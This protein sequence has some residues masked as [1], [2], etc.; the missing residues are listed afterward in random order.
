[1]K[2]K[3]RISSPNS[4][5]TRLNKRINYSATGGVGTGCCACCP[6]P[7]N[8]CDEPVTGCCDNDL[9][10]DIVYAHLSDAGGC[11][12]ING[13]TIPLDIIEP[14]RNAWN[15]SPGSSSG[16]TC[17]PG[18]LPSS[19]RDAFLACIDGTYN[20]T[21]VCG[22]DNSGAGDAISVTCDPF[23]LT[24]LLDMTFLEQNTCCDGL[25]SVVINTTP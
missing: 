11:S 17:S 13:T 16:G 18:Q 24:F 21:F 23:R 25:V 3:V 7:C 1:M 15:Y 5:L 14:E 22:A 20:F 4:G 9:H 10:P 8:C 19:I 2:F 12:C 6:D